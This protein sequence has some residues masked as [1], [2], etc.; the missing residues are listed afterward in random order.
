VK[1]MVLRG[2]LRLLLPLFWRL[3]CVAE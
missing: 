1:N 2:W 3:L